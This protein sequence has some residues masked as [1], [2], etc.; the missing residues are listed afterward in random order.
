[1]QEC[2]RGQRQHRWQSGDVLD[3]SERQ[4]VAGPSKT[5]IERMGV[6]DRHAAMAM[7]R[8]EASLRPKPIVRH[9]E[10][11]NKPLAACAHRPNHTIGSRRRINVWINP[12]AW[13][14]AAFPRICQEISNPVN[15]VDLPQHSA[16]IKATRLH[17]QRRTWNS[18]NLPL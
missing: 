15:N 18:T 12:S 2:H 10:C 1:V 17:Q 9:I 3:S 8:T 16:G 7:I 6:I 13:H 14:R 5:F 11:H 4:T